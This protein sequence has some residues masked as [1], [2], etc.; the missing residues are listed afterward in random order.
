MKKYLLVNLTILCAA[1]FLWAADEPK[2]AA[3]A[4]PKIDVEADATLSWGVD[5]GVGKNAEVKHG[6]KN[7][8][9]WKVTFPLISKGNLTSTHEDVPVYGE[10]IL[11]DVELGIQSKHDG[12]DFKADGKV[13][14]LSAKLHF[15]GLYMTVYNKPS[16]KADKAKIWDPADKKND[17]GEYDDAY[18]GG[19]AFAPEFKGYGF[20]LGYANKDLMDLDVGVKLGSNGNWEAE[21]KAPK[22]GDFKGVKH[23]KAGDKVGDDEFVLEGATTKG[24]GETIGTE[25][26][27]MV[28]KAKGASDGYHSKYGIG[29]DLGI[30]PLGKLLG[31]DAT[32]NATLSHAKTYQN[33]KGESNK[34]YDNGIGEKFNN[35][36]NKDHNYAD[37][38]F[39]NFGIGVSSEP[40]DGL[41]FNVGFDAGSKFNTGNQE[42]GLDVYGLG[43]DALA[44]VGF[45]WLEGGVYLASPNANVFA[46]MNMKKDSDKQN[47]MD[48]AA[49]VKFE[50]KGIAKDDGKEDDTKLVDGLDAGAFLGMYHLLSKMPEGAK[51]QLPMLAK[52]WAAYKLGIN[53]S[54]WVKPF[55]NFW[56]ET[57]SFNDDKG[58]SKL[59]L[60]YNVG[61]TFSPVE[62]VEVTAK[63]SQGKIEKNR[64]AAYVTDNVIVTPANGEKN[65]KGRFVLSLK[66]K[67]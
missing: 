11:K 15:Y 48:M 31:I 29:V 54:M 58:N 63:W 56:A 64:Y 66:V 57:N 43:W 20:K 38:A 7:A 17:D 52:V 33:D 18:K 65:H 24:P 55:A 51:V 23:F 39:L 16:F 26:D 4:E 30:K 59:G 14:G 28:L 13:D 21:A 41:K 60:A 40:I 36:I 47:I 5:L 42:K 34:G 25:G 9:S 53:D 10:V 61:A 32:V 44:K 3:L 1:A 67:Y 12:K 22:A 35:K 45:K 37:S 19:Y 46:G 49:F 2:V 62:K 50:T 8:A 27:Y 6:F